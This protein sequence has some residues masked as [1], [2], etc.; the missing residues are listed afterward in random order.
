MLRQIGPHLRIQI[1]EALESNWN[2]SGNWIAAVKQVMDDND[3]V[4][5]PGCGD[6]IDQDINVIVFNMV[7]GLRRSW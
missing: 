7:D 1:E 4:W 5:S 2:L 3:R 6:K